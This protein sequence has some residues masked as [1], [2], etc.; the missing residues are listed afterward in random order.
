MLFHGNLKMD[1]AELTILMIA[2][3]DPHNTTEK[4]EIEW[5]AAT[6]EWTNGEEL[7]V[8]IVTTHKI[9]T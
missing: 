1:A 4:L 9:C 6:L 7:L 5:S 8:K 2:S 3:T